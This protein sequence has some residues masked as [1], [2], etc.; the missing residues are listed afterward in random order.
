[1]PP[2]E[3]QKVC[4]HAARVGGRVL[5]D[6]LGK[7][8]VREKGRADLVTDADF[9]AQ[10]AICDLVLGTYPDH[11]FLGEE[12][13]ENHHRFT[14]RPERGINSSCFR[15]I[16][17]P[18][19]G[20]TNFV[21][22]VPL[23]ASSVALA[24]GNDVICGTVYI[25][26]LEECFTTAK[27]QGAF[28]NGEPIRTSNVT[29]FSEALASVSFPTTTESDSPDLLA[30]LKFLPITQAIRRTGSTA[31]NLAYI[32]AGRFDLMTCYG[33]NAWDV[34][35][36]VLLVREA[37]GVISDPSGGPFDLDKGATL[38]SATKTLHDKTVQLIN[39]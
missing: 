5:R 15:W 25:P 27:G 39:G 36:G 38:A 2:S 23:F 19:D 34:A 33:S 16:V 13:D 11:A 31:I 8:G 7:V 6:M 26:I 10:K 18:L 37:G 32:A 28:L 20:T 3:Y 1:M 22:G 4:E 30:F 14:P 17:D 21:H 12:I 29:E 35:A 24:H 9:A